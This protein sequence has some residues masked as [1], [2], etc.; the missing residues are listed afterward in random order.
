MMARIGLAREG[1]WMGCDVMWFGLCARCSH[2][3][4]RSCANFK[5]L[6]A[7]GYYDGMRAFFSSSSSSSVILYFFCSSSVR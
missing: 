3:A 5:T 1:G 2:H 4:P 6:A 7:Q